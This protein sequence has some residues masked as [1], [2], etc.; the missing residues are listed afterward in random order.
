M[1]KNVP[2]PSQG[3]FPPLFL[4]PP[5]LQKRKS[6][7]QLLEQL[8]VPVTR[9][10]TENLLS[11]PFL[12]NVFFF[13]FIPAL[14][15]RG[16]IENVSSGLCLA[17]YF[18]SWR[19]LR[20]EGDK[21][22]IKQHG[23]GCIPRRSR[24]RVRGMVFSHS[25]LDLGLAFCPLEKVGTNSPFAKAPGTTSPVSAARVRPARRAQAGAHHPLLHPPLPLFSSTSSSNAQFNGEE[26]RWP[27]RAA[28][29]RFRVSGGGSFPISLACLMLESALEHL[30]WVRRGARAKAVGGELWWGW[31]VFLAIAS[32]G[33]PG[34]IRRDLWPGGL[35]WE[36]GEQLGF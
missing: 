16:L 17:H 30:G 35:G 3:A 15:S 24:G 25:G 32:P 27:H 5:L 33:A 31:R 10:K 1:V 22:L 21:V 4:Q 23:F 6:R 34:G 28:G 7:H 19:E 12:F 9:G 20:L 18:L 29:D 11:C 2:A 26:P 14:E 36:G 13:F 8:G